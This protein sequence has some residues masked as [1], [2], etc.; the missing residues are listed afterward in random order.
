MKYIETYRRI[1]RGD[2]IKVNSTAYPTKKLAK[3]VS[4]YKI[5]SNIRFVVK[6]AGS[7][8][9]DV[10]VDCVIFETDQEPC[11]CPLP[12]LMRSGCLCG[13]H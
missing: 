2:I 13:G 12:A 10:H 1:N 5:N 3:V 11:D 6:L 4:I 9:V 7:I 8:Q